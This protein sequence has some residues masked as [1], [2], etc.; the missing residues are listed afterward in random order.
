MRI[1]KKIIVLLCIMLGMLF[2]NTLKVEAMTFEYDNKKLSVGDT[3]DIG[4]QDYMKKNNN[5]YCVEK[6]DFVEKRR[7]EYEVV[8]RVQIKSDKVVIKYEGKD[9]ITLNDR[10]N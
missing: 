2:F 6:G 1:A 4:F 5:L 9:K 3:I 7:R 8:G 10:R